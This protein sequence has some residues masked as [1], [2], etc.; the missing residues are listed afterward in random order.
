MAYHAWLT[1]YKPPP[2]ESTIYVVVDTNILLGYYEALRTFVEDVEK[3]E[4][5]VVVV[6]PGIVVQELDR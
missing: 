3:V 5:P 4:A 6:F 2:L 1:M